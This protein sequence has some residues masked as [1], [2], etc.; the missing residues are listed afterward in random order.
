MADLVVA[1]RTSLDMQVDERTS[2]STD[3]CVT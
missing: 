2:R 1:F 3:S